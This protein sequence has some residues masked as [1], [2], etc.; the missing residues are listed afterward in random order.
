MPCTA[1]VAQF[2]VPQGISERLQPEQAPSTWYSVRPVYTGAQ[3]SNLH[4]CGLGNIIQSPPSLSCPPPT[5][6]LYAP[7]PLHRSYSTTTTTT[8]ALLLLLR[9]LLLLHLTHF[10]SSPI[11][12]IVN[13][14]STQCSE[15]R[16]TGGLASD[17]SVDWRVTFN[18]LTIQPLHGR[19]AP[20]N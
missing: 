7:I 4:R 18:I 9:L 12:F 11:S 16:P 5:H 13:S 3:C 15:S 14:F 6:T 8:L 19:T 2:S 1:C 17:I 10:I 20:S